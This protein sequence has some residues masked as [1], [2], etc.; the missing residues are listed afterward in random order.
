[1]RVIEG[2]ENIDTTI[3]NVAVTIGNFDG[4]HLGHQRLISRTVEL[5]RQHRLSAVAMTFDRNPLTVLRPDKAPAAILPL[6]RRIEIIKELGIDV[7]V[8]LPCTQQTLDTTVEQFTRE[9]IAGRLATRF[10]VEGKTFTFGKGGVGDIEYLKQASS[11]YGFEAIRLD[12]VELDLDDYGRQAVSSSLVRRLIC[13]G[14]MELVCR[15]LGRPFELIGPVIA[16]KA[17]GVKLG[18]PTANICTGDQI[19]PPHGVYAGWVYLNDH[20]QRHAA[21]GYVGSA[22][23]FDDQDVQVEAFLL[24]FDGNLYDRRV[25]L[26][27]LKRLRGQMRFE[28]S[29]TLAEQIAEDCR[30]VRDVL[31]Q[32]TA[33]K[34]DSKP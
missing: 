1:M 29:R 32:L 15:C 10:I 16:G 9:V 17:R 24:D 5:A 20:P 22:P 23:T 34:A 4:V 2:I 7:L 6:E 25:R 11:R 3:R 28:D 26:Q 21:A 31:N 13:H 12:Q 27:L 18:Y 30:Q 33:E 19:L 8:I 14:R